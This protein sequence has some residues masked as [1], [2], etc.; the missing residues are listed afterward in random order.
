[1]AIENEEDEDKARAHYDRG[2]AHREAG[3]LDEAIAEFE[4]AMQSSSHVVLGHIMIGLC[5][6][7]QAHYADA[8]RSFQAGLSADTITPRERLALL[9]ELGQLRQHTGDLEA[10][11]ECFEKVASQD[12]SYR[13]VR[14]KMAAIR[15]QPKL[16]Q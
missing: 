3:H 16:W 12:P 4:S 6:V 11:L 9:F 13:D 5:H 14:S 1:M 8:E 10:A 2:I 7:E 15:G